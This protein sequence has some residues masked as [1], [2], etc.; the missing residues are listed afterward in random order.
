MTAFRP[1]VEST[2]TTLSAV[3]ERRLIPRK[4]T[5]GRPM[6]AAGDVPKDPI[7]SR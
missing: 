5:S 1:S 2:I 6:P 7:L 4:D 3:A